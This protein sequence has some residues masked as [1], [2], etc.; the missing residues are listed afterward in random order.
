M[1]IYSCH[2]ASF[3]GFFTL[4]WHSGLPPGS[5]S[6]HWPNGTRRRD[7][8]TGPR[9][10]IT[11]PTVEYF[12]L[13]ISGRQS[14]PAQEHELHQHS[15][16]FQQSQPGDGRPDVGQNEREGKCLHHRLANPESWILNP[17]LFISRWKSTARI[18]N[19]SSR[20]YPE[21]FCPRNTAVT[22]WRWPSSRVT[23]I[24]SIANRPDAILELIPFHR[25]EMWKAKV[26]AHRDF[27]LER[28]KMKSVEAQRPGRPKTSQDLFGIEG[29]FRQLNIDWFLSPWR[30][31]AHSLLCYRHLGSISNI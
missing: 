15:S 11:E 23:C 14:D 2:S 21:T 16:G 27:L 29:S 4:D 19:P 7:I 20:K 5:I 13:R 3:G 6:F 24:T 12:W 10:S 1:I 22:G 26:T 8:E 28:Q 31:H 17:F 9:R 25:P 18:G 30:T